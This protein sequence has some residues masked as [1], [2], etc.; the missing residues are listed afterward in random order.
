MIDFH[1]TSIDWFP[2]KWN[3]G[4]EWIEHTFIPCIK[5]GRQKTKK[6]KLN[7]EIPKHNRKTFEPKS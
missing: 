1:C 7:L 5:H 3:F 4:V 6:W 2:Y